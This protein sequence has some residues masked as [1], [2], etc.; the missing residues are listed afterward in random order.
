MKTYLKLYRVARQYYEHQHG[1]TGW[2]GVIACAV[3]TGSAFGKARS[4]L[5]KHG[6][7]NGEGS[8]M[9]AIN[10]TLRDL[11]YKPETLWKGEDYKSATLHTAIKE[12]AKRNGTFFIYSKK[13]KMAHVTC[14]KDGQVEDWAHPDIYPTARLRADR[15]VVYWVTKITKTQV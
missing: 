5:Y 7:K 12:F 8:A 10:A 13:G 15:R 2:C 9:D 4:I 11:G 1:E 6:R 14:V 3:A